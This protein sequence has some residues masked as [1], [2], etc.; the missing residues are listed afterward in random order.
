MR[1]ALDVSIQ[2]LG[3]PTGVERAQAV[4]VDGL[5]ELDGDHELLL[6]G[7]GQLP[8]H[9]QEHR[10]VLVAAPGRGLVWRRTA[11]PAALMR[12]RAHLLH[13][14]VAAAPPLSPC[15][16]VATLHELPWAEPDS[17]G[18]R[19][20]FHRLAT[21]SAS[22][23]AWRLVCPSA[24]TARQLARLH[25]AA[26]DRVRVVPHGVDRRFVRSADAA[27]AAASEAQAEARAAL[28]RLGV[29]RAGQYVL[30]V[31]RLRS[32][33]NLLA[34]MDAHRLAVLQGAASQLVL[35]GPPGD[36]VERLLLMGRR[37]QPGSVLLPG[38]VPE[39]LLP[40]LYAGAAAVLVP[41]LIEGFGLTALEAMAS[42]VP[43]L[44]SAQGAVAE[45]VGDAALRVDGRDAAAMARG[46]VH[47]CADHSLR[48]RLILAGR[49]QAARRSAAAQAAATLAVY[50]E[51]R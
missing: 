18:D 35:A 5:L 12:H 16:V 44:A 13:S 46:I 48:Q 47:L 8:E 23:R 2:G 20:L 38:F 27:T 26:A 34:L 22:R 25:P 1:I 9:W 10:R 11:L 30:A 21:A 50:A 41:S 3:D 42:G 6:L 43:V 31:G 37:A 14:P 28:D 33:K 15:P 4:L 40:E 32:K 29:A 51:S 39:A 36:D 7:G 24:R 19:R 17:P 45:S 49:Q